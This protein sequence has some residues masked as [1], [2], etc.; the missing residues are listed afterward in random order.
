MLND[1]VLRGLLVISLLCCFHMQCTTCDDRQDFPER[2][3][4][5]DR[6]IARSD[7]ISISIEEDSSNEEQL[8]KKMLSQMGSALENNK[9]TTRTRRAIFGQDNRVSVDA[10]LEAQTYPYSTVVSLSSGCTGTLIGVQHVLTAAH[11]VHDGKKYLKASK[12][13]KIGMLQRSGKFHWI[14]VRKIYFPKAWKKQSKQQRIKHDYAVLELRRP[15]SRPTMTVEPSALIRGSPMRFVGFHGDKWFNSMWR[16]QCR[17]AV[18][19]KGALLSFCD[20]QKGI[21]G[22]GVYVRSGVRNAVVGV[23]SAIGRGR[24]RGKQHVFNVAISIDAR[25]VRNIKKWMQRMSRRRH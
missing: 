1:V 5:K 23:V 17:V 11:C 24:L 15:H 16:S 19:I 25:K 22:S 3:R 4:K 10:S 8:L 6:Q 2:S 21:S 18:V 9:D 20:G 13:L 14:K 7:V 12:N